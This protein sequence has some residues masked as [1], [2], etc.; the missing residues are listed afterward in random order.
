MSEKNIVEGLEWG[1]D[2]FQYIQMNHELGLETDK[3]TFLGINGPKGIGKE[4]LMKKI[5]NILKREFI[6]IDYVAV[7]YTHLRAHETF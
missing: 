7:S 4:I 1:K 6:C 5:C 2:V 3:T